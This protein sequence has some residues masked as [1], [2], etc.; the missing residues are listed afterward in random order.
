MAPL[1]CH[2]T[3]KVNKS[4]HLTYMTTNIDII[5]LIYYILSRKKYCTSPE[6]GL[7]RNASG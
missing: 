1:A 4:K 6:Y 3:K 2:T 7:S 5:D